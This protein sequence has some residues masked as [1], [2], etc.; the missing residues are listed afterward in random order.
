VLGRDARSHPAPLTEI[1]QFYERVFLL[2]L[3]FFPQAGEPYKEQKQLKDTFRL[4][5]APQSQATERAN[6][7]QL[8]RTWS[9]WTRS[10]R[11]AEEPQLLLHSMETACMLQP[12]PVLPSSPTSPHTAEP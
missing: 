5:T 8:S 1:T 10:G 6:R 7:S 2:F 11:K 4:L 9:G 12:G 3:Q